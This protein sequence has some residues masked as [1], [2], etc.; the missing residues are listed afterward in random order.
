MKGVIILT[1]L[2]VGCAHGSAGALYTSEEYQDREGLAVS[3][4]KPEQALIPE[5]GIQRLLRSKI[6]IP[7]R[8][9]LA[10]HA[11]PHRSVEL[12]HWSRPEI[13]ESRRDALSALEGPLS[14]TRRFS[15][16]THVPR[17]LLPED[18][19]LTRLREAAALLQADLLLVYATRSERST[20]V[21]LFVPNEVKVATSLEIFLMDVRTGVVPYAEAFEVVRTVAQ[22]K[23]DD[24]VA[25]TQRRAEREGIVETL[26]EAAESLRAFF[27]R[28]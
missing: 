20:S 14:E 24:R 13:L 22:T 12:G 3:V 2:A 9:K 11:F 25:E 4:L 18:P 28:G 16:I 23:D 8:A 10:V 19:S 7:A 17:M 15:E 27:Q 1:L 5:E 26:K 6:E 21:Y